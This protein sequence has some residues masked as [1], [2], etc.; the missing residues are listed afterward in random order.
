MY[1]ASNVQSDN[2]RQ[3]RHFVIFMGIFYS[4]IK[5]IG[6]NQTSASAAVAAAAQNSKIFSRWPSKCN[7]SCV[8]VVKCL[9]CENGNIDFDISVIADNG[10]A[11][12]MLYNV[13]GILCCERRNK[14]R[15]SSIL[16]LIFPFSADR[17]FDRSLAGAKC[18]IAKIKSMGKYGRFTFHLL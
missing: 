13:E 15:G 9:L 6:A 12:L 14:D 8:Y 11:I 10:P 5:L 2:D 17:E 16:S 18:T 3:D 7:N 1:V 4:A